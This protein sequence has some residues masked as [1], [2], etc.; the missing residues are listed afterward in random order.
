RACRG[1]PGLRSH[2]S[3]ISGNSCQSTSSELPADGF[4]RKRLAGTISMIMSHLFNRCDEEDGQ[5]ELLDDFSNRELFYEC[6]QPTEFSRTAASAPKPRR[7][8]RR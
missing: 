4:A 5:A 7:S 8:P 1:R 3:R 6:S 2:R